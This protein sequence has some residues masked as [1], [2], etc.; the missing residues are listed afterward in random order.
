[1][2]RLDADSARVA[3]INAI[4]VGKEATAPVVGYREGAS[5]IERVAPIFPAIAWLVGDV[6]NSVVGACS[7]QDPHNLSPLWADARGQL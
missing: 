5:V 6:I 2:G 4:H 3:G 1:M 7:A